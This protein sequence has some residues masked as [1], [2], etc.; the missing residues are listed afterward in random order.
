M[1]S[2]APQWRR[3]NIELRL[4][5]RR[6]STPSG[7]YDKRELTAYRTMYGLLCKAILR[8][9]SCRRDRHEL[10]RAIA[11]AP[12]GSRVTFLMHR[13]CRRDRHE[14]MR[15]IAD[16]SQ[17][18]R[19]TF[20]MRHRCRRDRHELLRAIADASQVARATFL[21]R[22]CCRHDRHELMCAIA[23]ACR[24]LHGQNF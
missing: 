6:P 8:K 12:Q 21:M 17:V 7:N 9:C 23:D 19:A 15:A 2:N 18:A 13:K 11:D 16:A 10:L 5:A 22:R 14:L 20:L 4:N 24:K 1:Q 3:E